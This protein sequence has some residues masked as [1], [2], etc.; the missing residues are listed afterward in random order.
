MRWNDFQEF[1][2][3]GFTFCLVAVP[4]LT[5]IFPSNWNGNTAKGNGDHQEIDADFAKLPV[6]S[7]HCQD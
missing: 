4:I 5:Q 2:E 7:I 6:C 3:Y 1:L